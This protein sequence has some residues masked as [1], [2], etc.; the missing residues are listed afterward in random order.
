MTPLDMSD[1]MVTLNMRK[2][3]L[4]PPP[5]LSLLSLESLFTRK[6]TTLTLSRESKWLTQSCIL[7]VLQQLGKTTYRN[8]CIHLTYIHGLMSGF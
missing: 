6:N 3:K 7:P 1:L 8:G 2:E 5:S 4:E